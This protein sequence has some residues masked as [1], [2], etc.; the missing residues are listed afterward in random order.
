WVRRGW[1]RALRQQKSREEASLARPGIAG[2][3]DLAGTVGPGLSGAMGMFHAAVPQGDLAFEYK[4]DRLTPV[5]VPRGPRAG[6]E[7]HHELYDFGLQGSARDVEPR[8]RDNPA[9]CGNAGI[10]TDNGRRARGRRD[11]DGQNPPPRIVGA[12]GHRASVVPSTRRAD[13]GAA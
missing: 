13:P 12:I 9:V 11:R 3:V 5:R 7:V 2:G 4:I 8:L 1:R 6:R 10:E